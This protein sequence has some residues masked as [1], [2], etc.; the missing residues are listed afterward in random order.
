M[1]VMPT[2]YTGEFGLRLPALFRDVPT[3][4]AGMAS[5]AWIDQDHKDP[6]PL[7]FVRHKIA[8]LPKTPIG[9]LIALASTNRRPASDVRQV[10][11]HQ[12]CLRVFG[13]HHK[14]FGNCMVHPPL[15]PRLESCQLL[16]PPFGTFRR[17]GLIGLAMERTALADNF[18]RFPGVA[19]AIAIGRA[20]SRVPV[21]SSSGLRCGA[22][23]PVVP[24]ARRHSGGPGGH[25]DR[26][27]GG[28]G[29]TLPG[30]GGLHQ[31]RRLPVR[32][33]HAWADWLCGADPVAQR[34]VRHTQ[35]PP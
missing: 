20:S 2:T 11:E 23:R 24:A 1:G 18:D 31:V 17:R 22:A 4:R 3:F 7:G 5:I 25:D 28:G 27:A 34:A 15:E 8:Q 26:G 33:L 19:L 9:V 16:Q 29:S 30:A 35:K 21:H 6:R 32:V 10:F 12:H 13:L 14:L